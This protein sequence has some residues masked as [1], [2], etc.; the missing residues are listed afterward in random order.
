M[1][2]VKPRAREDVRSDEEWAFVRWLQEAIRLDLISDWS[3]EPRQ[4]ELFASRC[5][6]EVVQMKTRTKIEG[7]HLHRAESYTPDFMIEMTP[8]GALKL[9]NAF[10]LSMLAAGWASGEPAVVW[11]DVKGN[12]SPYQTDERYFSIV[13]KAMYS[14]H[15][16][17]V[18]KVIPFYD[19]NKGLFSETFAPE[20]FRWMK[21][22]SVPT[23]TS[24]GRACQSA[25][26]FAKVLPTPEKQLDL[27]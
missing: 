22:R 6:P 17:W 4:F 7:R 23:L 8:S 5:V 21:N 20:E 2:P 25:E 13:R 9:Y 18:S 14:A 26:K 16:I 3:Y 24:C 15:G 19:R 11:V 1:I 27:I 12:F 10:K